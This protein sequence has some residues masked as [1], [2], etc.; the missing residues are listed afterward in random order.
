VDDD[1]PA[2]FHTIQEAI[3]AA[4]DGDTIYV[5]AGIYY[6]NVVVYGC[7]GV[8]TSH[9]SNLSQVWIYSVDNTHDYDVLYCYPS[10]FQL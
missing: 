9:Q 1:G 8:F 3:N 2:D 5:R 4:S 10:H 7:K 6:E